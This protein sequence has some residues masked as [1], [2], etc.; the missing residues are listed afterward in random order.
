MK[1][2]MQAQEIREAAEW[3]SGDSVEMA[4]IADIWKD[5]EEYV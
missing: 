4:V 3:I 2:M 5:R 1:K